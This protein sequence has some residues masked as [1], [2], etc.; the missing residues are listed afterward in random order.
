[1]LIPS[2]AENSIVKL[3]TTSIIEFDLLFKA[4]A[5]K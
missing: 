3:P 4:L 1:L 2:L 5:D